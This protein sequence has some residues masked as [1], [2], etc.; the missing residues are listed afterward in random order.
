MPELVD[1]LLAGLATALRRAAEALPGIVAFA[2]IVFIGYY[3]GKAVGGIVTRLLETTG[4]TR[5]LEETEFGKSLSKAGFSLSRFIGWLVHAYIF[6]IALLLGIDYLRISG[7]AASIIQSAVSYLPNLLAG[8]M[9]ITFGVLFVEL[10]T[11]YLAGILS[12]QGDQ[13]I[14]QLLPEILKI[15]LVVA[16]IVIGLDIM[17]LTQFTL[18]YGLIIGFLIIATGIVITDAL[19]EQITSA[20]EEFRPAAGAAKFVLYMIFLLIGIGGIFSSYPYVVEVIK[21]LSW[22]VAIA[23]GIVIAPLI[24]KMIK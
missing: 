4:L 13:K 19:I 24:Y 2:I 11:S 23:T 20:H 14:L 9:V 12:G 8:I 18:V 6:V 1:Y 15:A 7:A 5:K 17:K 21:T 16:I 22:A 10:L 3:I